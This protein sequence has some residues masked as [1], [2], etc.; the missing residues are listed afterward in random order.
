MKKIY[1]GTRTTNGIA[2][3]VTIINHRTRMRV[4]SL[5]HIPCHSP[6]GFEWGYHGSG[7]ADLALA[8]LVDYLRERPPRNGWVAG[9]RFSRWSVASLAFRHHQSFK[10]DLIARWGEGWEL[11]DAQIEV[12][13]ST[14][15]RS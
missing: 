14:R 9:E 4:R 2:V 6:D 10:R 15:S 8:L 7:P 11:E 1:R 5:R 3:S 12:W 13:L